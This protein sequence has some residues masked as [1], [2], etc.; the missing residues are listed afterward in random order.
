MRKKHSIYSNDEIDIRELFKMLWNEK[1]KITLIALIS[2][3]IIIA[4]NNYK[5]KQ[6]NSFKNTLIII[7]GN[8]SN[9]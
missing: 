9:N 3:V 7:Y 8:N 1:I 2:F 6:P 4:Y 5:P